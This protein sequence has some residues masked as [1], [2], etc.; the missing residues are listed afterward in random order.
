MP[1]FAQCNGKERWPVK[2]GND[3]D[4][5]K[6]NTSPVTIS[7]D[8]MN[9]WNGG[10]P[11][12]WAALRKKTKTRISP[13]ELQ[14]YHVEGM[15]T[16]YKCECN[17]TKGDQDY[18]LVIQSESG[19]SIIAEIPNPLCVGAGSPFKAQIKK[20]RATMNSKFSPQD[21]KQ[22]AMVRVAIEGPAFF[23]KAHGQLGRAENSIEIHPVMNLKFLN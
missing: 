3:L 7:I 21:K 6:V 14:V 15:L 8:I 2:T 4:V 20:A 16:W 19:Q 5:S 1:A 23:D 10:A 13:Y 12:T 17:S 9:T 11:Y 22:K 18:H